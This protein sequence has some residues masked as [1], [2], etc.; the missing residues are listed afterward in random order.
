MG[1]WRACGC[2]LLR[3]FVGAALVVVV[4][5]KHVSSKPHM[6]WVAHRV[7]RFGI[8]TFGSRRSARRSQDEP[9]CFF[10]FVV[11]NMSLVTCWLLFVARCM[12]LESSDLLFVCCCLPSVVSRLLFVV[13][14][15]Y[16]ESIWICVFWSHVCMLPASHLYKHRCS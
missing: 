12:L 13:F 11:Y 5:V 8:I 10:V 16:S 9:C 3:H 6:C 7:W 15:F 4:F 1:T 14:G 2:F